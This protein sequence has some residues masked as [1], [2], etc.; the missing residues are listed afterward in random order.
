MIYA[1]TLCNEFLGFNKKKYNYYCAAAR[2]V[3]NFVFTR[4]RHCAY[5]RHSPWLSS[6]RCCDIITICVYSTGPRCREDTCI[7][8]I[9]NILSQKSQNRLTNI[10]ALSSITRVPRTQS[11]TTVYST[12]KDRDLFSRYL[13]KW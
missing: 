1:H 12:Y 10:C 8:D 2:V 7:T 11:N 13:S 3:V 6:A 5:S 9:H 4:C